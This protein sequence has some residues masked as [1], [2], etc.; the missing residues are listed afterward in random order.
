[1]KKVVIGCSVLRKEIEAALSEHSDF[2]FVWLED[3]LHNTPE[4]LHEKVQDAVD[5]ASDADQIY[6]IYG[7]CG[8][9]LTG[10]EA[11]HCPLVLPKVED[12]I[13]V[14][15]YKNPDVEEMRRSSYFVSQG[16]LWGEE[17]LG[18]DYDRMKEKRGEKRA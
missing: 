8:Q 4:V 3:Q 2:D 16:W 18:Y 15:L 1:M 10:V 13:D 6:L 11:R 9:A 12:C 17:G 14:L 7:H 5:G